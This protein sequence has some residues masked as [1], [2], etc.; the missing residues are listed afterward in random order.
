VVTGSHPYAKS[1]GYKVTTTIR[2]AGGSS[3]KTTLTLQAV[4]TGSSAAVAG[5]DNG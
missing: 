5:K 4:A 1:G 2:D 3:L